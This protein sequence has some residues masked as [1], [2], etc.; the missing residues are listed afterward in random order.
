MARKTFQ[1]GNHIR[2]N[3]FDFSDNTLHCIRQQKTQFQLASS[4]SFEDIYKHYCISVVLS[5][6]IINQIFTVE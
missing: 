4:D 2:L 1:F 5:A 6:L 3:I